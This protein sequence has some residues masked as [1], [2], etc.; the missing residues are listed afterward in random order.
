MI[1]GFRKSL[2]SW[3]VVAIL[4]FSL[5]AIVVTGFG[6]G[7]FG[8][9]GSLS[10]GGRRSDGSDTLATI[11][12]RTLSAS[13]V[14]DLVN[15]QFANVRQQQ[16]TLEMAGFLAQGAFEQTVDQLITARALEAFGSRQGLV[17]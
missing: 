13:E 8:G 16:P 10:G 4:F 9:L 1:S 3:I 17:A 12:G 11:N 2:R 5:I 7:G 6:T 15:R 14:T